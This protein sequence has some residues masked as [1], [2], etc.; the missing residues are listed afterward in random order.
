MSDEKKRE[1]TEA[2]HWR[3]IRQQMAEIR[4]AEDPRPKTYVRFEDIAVLY[5]D[6]EFFFTPR[7][8]LTREQR[9]AN[10]VFWA[11]QPAK[12]P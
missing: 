8:F 2:E 12:R 1:P 10:H 9:I 6:G 3:D 7:Q 5:R 4:E 11:Q